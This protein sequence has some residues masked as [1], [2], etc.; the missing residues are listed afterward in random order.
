MGRQKR[1]RAVYKKE[2]QG[3]ATASVLLSDVLVLLSGLCDLLKKVGCVLRKGCARVMNEWL[4]KGSSGPYGNNGA[5][6]D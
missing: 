6:G 3:P 5:V 1:K 4:A 2:Q